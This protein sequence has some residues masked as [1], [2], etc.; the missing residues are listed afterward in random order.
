MFPAAFSPYTVARP[1]R[2]GSCIATPARAPRRTTEATPIATETTTRLPAASAPGGGHPIRLL[3]VLGLI[4]F[5]NFV[6][7]LVIVPLFPLLRDQ[8]S[9]TDAQLGTLQTVMQVVLALST[10]PFA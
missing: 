9:L 3:V 4:N 2:P 10:V 5:I 6:E 7:R 8:F 1:G